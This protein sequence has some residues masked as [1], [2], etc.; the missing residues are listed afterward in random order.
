MDVVE[1]YVNVLDTME[2]DLSDPEV[3]KRFSLWNIVEANDQMRKFD[4]AIEAHKARAAG[5]PAP[6]PAGATP[7][8]LVDPADSLIK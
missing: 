5:K 1:E 4:E 7:K 3:D 2:L 8:T 6:T